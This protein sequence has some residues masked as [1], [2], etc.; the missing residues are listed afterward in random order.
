MK[1]TVLLPALLLAAALAACAGDPVPAPDAAA[2]P[3]APAPRAGAGPL[4]ERALGGPSTAD[5]SAGPASVRDP[6]PGA[7]HRVGEAVRKGDLVV[8]LVEGRAAAGTVEARF[9]IHNAGAHDAVVSPG[10]FRLR[11]GGDRPRMRLR[12][13]PAPLPVGQLRPGETLRGSVTW[14]AS[15]DGEVRVAFADGAGSVEWTLPG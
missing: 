4:A 11:S 14:D 6:V 9:E 2:G 5:G 7:T 3:V 13:P 15:T 1:R 8:T 10:N 12:Q